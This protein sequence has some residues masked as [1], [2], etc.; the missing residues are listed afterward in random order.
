MP[1]TSHQVNEGEPTGEGKV[2]REKTRCASPRASPT[3]RSPSRTRSRSGE[4]RDASGQRARIACGN[5]KTSP[6]S[7]IAFTRCRRA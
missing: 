3:R 5:V 2:A 7:Y 4:R 1:I 6:G